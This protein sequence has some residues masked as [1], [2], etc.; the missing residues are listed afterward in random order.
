VV[1][2]F[3]DGIVLSADDFVV[4]GRHLVQVMCEDQTIVGDWVEFGESP[5]FGCM[6]GESVCFGNGGDEAVSSGGVGNENDSGGGGI[7]LSAS[8][9]TLGSGGAV[10][11]GGILYNFLVAAPLQD[12][13]TF[14]EDNPASVTLA[15]WD[16]LNADWNS[17]RFTTLGLL[18]VG[19]A[20]TGIGG[21]LYYTEG[22]SVSLT[23]NSILVT[24][25]F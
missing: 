21:Y 2:V 18:G 14:V 6:C 16:A 23:P 9:I 22:Q 19:A 8:T 13:V 11:V 15:Q 24:G 5:D 3:L 17:A 7:A 4:Q 10:L 25:S 20:V 1:R 12:E